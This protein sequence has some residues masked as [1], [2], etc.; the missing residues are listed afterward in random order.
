M[1]YNIFN[2]LR[3]HVIKFHVTQWLHTI[4]SFPPNLIY[5]S[6]FKLFFN[7]ENWFHKVRQL[8]NEIKNSYYKVITRVW[9]KFII[10][11]VRYYKV[12]QV[13]ESVTDCYYKVRQ[14]LQCSTFITKW[15]VTHVL[16]LQMWHCRMKKEEKITIPKL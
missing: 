8:K 5:M 4:S 6:F 11:C 12:Y 13:A 14:V 3:D 10:K 7:T 2:L 16:N 9:Q 1:W 15:D